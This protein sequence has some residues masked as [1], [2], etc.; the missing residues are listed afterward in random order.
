MHAAD[1]NA[2]I[3]TLRA[4]ARKKP[5][6]KTKTRTG[7]PL[8]ASLPL[9]SAPAVLHI[10]LYALDVF[11]QVRLRQPVARMSWHI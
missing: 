9:C 6:N 2:R 7:F 3:S 1:Y 5:K 8:S 4:R 11:Q 10:D